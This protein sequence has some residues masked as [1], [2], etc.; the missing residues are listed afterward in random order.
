MNP[1]SL[2]IN[3]KDYRFISNSIN[4][5]L[6]QKMYTNEIKILDTLKQKESFYYVFYS[7]LLKLHNCYLYG[8]HL[9]LNFLFL[10]Y[11]EF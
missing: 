10:N 6:K 1:K 5:K 7:F 8:F 3:H 9:I 11:N 2:F 4:Y